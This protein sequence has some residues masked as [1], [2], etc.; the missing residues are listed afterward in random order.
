MAIVGG[1]GLSVWPNASI[2]IC[3]AVTGPIMAQASDLWGRRWFL[4]VACTAAVVGSL[5]TSRA[6]S[7]KMVIAGQVVAGLGFGSQVR[8]SH[9]LSSIVYAKIQADA[10]GSPFQPLAYAIPSEI[11]PRKYRNAAQAFVNGAGGVGAILGL[12]FG[13]AITR[14]GRDDRIRIVSAA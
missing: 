7:M 5:V 11:L 6:S 8:H 13:G 12:I 1:S 2:A 9:S 4:I 14:N 3:T 10:F